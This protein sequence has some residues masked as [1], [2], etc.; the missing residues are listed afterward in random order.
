MG[1]KYSWTSREMALKV[2]SLKKL[3]YRQNDIAE[4]L[5]MHRSTVSR[6]VRQPDNYIEER[7]TSFQ[8]ME[9]KSIGLQCYDCEVFFE[10]PNGHPCV[11]ESCA[12]RRQNLIS[13]WKK[14]KFRDF[15]GEERDELIFEVM[16]FLENPLPVSEVSEVSLESLVRVV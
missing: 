3:G 12:K 16:E 4:M 5:N 10:H 7:L 8:V 14:S 9:N 11:C 15:E 13:I 1:K 2:L 6:I